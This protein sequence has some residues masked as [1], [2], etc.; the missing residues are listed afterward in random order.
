MNQPIKLDDE[1]LS[2][3][4]NIAE[5]AVLA[6]I[7]NVIVEDETIRG[8]SDSKSVAIVHNRNGEVKLPF[9]KIALSRLGLFL[10][11]LTSAKKNNPGFAVTADVDDDN[12]FVRIL[13][14]AGKNKA[15]EYRCAN[16][17][18]ISA[19]KNIRDTFSYQIVCTPAVLDDLKDAS[20]AMDSD[21][22]ILQGNS[23]GTSILVK[24]INNDTYQADFAGKPTTLNGGTI[25]DFSH[26]Y[27]TK[28]LLTLLKPTPD[29]NLV[30]GEKGVLN[31]VVRGLT[32]YVLPLV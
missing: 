18:T 28:T 10:F 25:P 3:V 6:G 9:E 7:E 19:P 17:N 11:R 26:R 4:Q 22:V 8:I 29:I 13:K 1:Q 31:M 30:I 27:S 32:I 21:S 12:E 23:K 16:P 20:A 24:D 15:V 2:Y 14:M 5:V